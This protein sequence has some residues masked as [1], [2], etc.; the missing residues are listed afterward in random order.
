MKMTL[1]W[2][3]GGVGACNTLPALPGKVQFSRGG[4]A[5]GGKGALARRS[6]CA[7]ESFLEFFKLGMLAGPRSLHV[8]HW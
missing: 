6:L 2:N 7:L 1:N 3:G 4:G 8:E 5:A